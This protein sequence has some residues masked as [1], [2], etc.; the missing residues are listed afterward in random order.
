MGRGGIGNADTPNSLTPRKMPKGQY[1]RKPKNPD[2]PT[3][4]SAAKD[5]P[6]IGAVPNEQDRIKALEQIIERQQKESA[7]R[8]ALL[9]E[10]AQEVRSNA[11]VRKKGGS[12]FDPADPAFLATIERIARGKTSEGGIIRDGFVPD[13]DKM[14]KPVIV[15]TNKSGLYIE[16]IK[17]GNTLMSLPDGIRGPLKFDTLYR[18]G[19][20]DTMRISYRG[21]M[22]V[23]SKRLFEALKKD[24]RWGIDFMLDEKVLTRKDKNHRW[25]QYYNTFMRVWMG[26]DENLVLAE[27]KRLKIPTSAMTTNK[28]YRELIAIALADEAVA[29]ESSNALAESAIDNA[30]QLLKTGAAQAVQA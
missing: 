15:F 22:I 10:L 19:E 1:D 21:V 12:S 16:H 14:D 7:A 26:R 20:Q 29:E 6:T 11:E 2:N 8:D 27:A 5:T 23:E 28:E 9:K 30:D 25:T 17:R 13:D 3:P 18:G 24:D 4:M